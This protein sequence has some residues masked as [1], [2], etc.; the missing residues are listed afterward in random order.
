[1]S[2][3]H[4]SRVPFLAFRSS[5]GLSAGYRRLRAAKVLAIL[6]VVVL[7]LAYI[8][9]AGHALIAIWG[10]IACFCWMF[11]AGASLASGNHSASSEPMFMR[12]LTLAQQMEAAA[13]REAIYKD[14]CRARGIEPKNPM[15]HER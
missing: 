2:L 11:I 15:P 5:F 1:M 7:T 13:R 3:T 9:A 4:K 8:F 10:G 12:P 6:A 14:M